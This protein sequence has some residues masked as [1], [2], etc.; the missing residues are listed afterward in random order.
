[1]KRLDDETQELDTDS[2]QDIGDRSV[3]SMSKESLFER[4]SQQRTV[5]RMVEA[6]LG[7]SLMDRS[8]FAQAAGMM[9]RCEGWKLSLGHN[10]AFD[11]RRL[12]KKSGA[13]AHRQQRRSRRRHS[14]SIGKALFYRV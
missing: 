6:A 14:P 7:V 4:T 5:L 8:G 2:V 10:I 9:F 11:V 3:L 13:A 12:S 1:M